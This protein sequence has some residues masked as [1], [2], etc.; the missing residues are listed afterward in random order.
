MEQRSDLRPNLFTYSV[1]LIH[2][3]NSVLLLASSAKP[4]LVPS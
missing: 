4:D 3:L 2:K 1:L